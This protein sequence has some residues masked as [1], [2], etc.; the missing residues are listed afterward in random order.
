L[1]VKQVAALRQVNKETL[2][3]F[4]KNYIQRGAPKRKK[5]CLQVFGGAH[6]TEYEAAIKGDSGSDFIPAE[7]SIQ[8][9]DVVTN[10]AITVNPVANGNL[11]VKKSRNQVKL[12]D[13]I[14]GFKRSQC[15]Y[16]SLKD[17]VDPVHESAK[18]S[19]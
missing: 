10:G 4:F 6:S 7:E 18:I 9:E 5:L 1:N 17:R 3:T 8:G 2:L 15:L 14:F 19:Q 12:I 16:E 13:D 11:K